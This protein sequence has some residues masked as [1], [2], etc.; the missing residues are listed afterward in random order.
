[1]K[2]NDYLIALPLIL[3]LLICQGLFFLVQRSTAE[4]TSNA[5]EFQIRETIRTDDMTPIAASIGNLESLKLIK[6]AKLT[7]LE[8]PVRE[9]VD[10]TNSIECDASPLLLQG[11][12]TTLFTNSTNG[13]RWRVSFIT[14]NQ[15]TFQIALNLARILGLGLILLSWQIVRVQTQ[16]QR[17]LVEVQ[18]NASRELTSIAN[19]VAHDI[20]SPLSVLA[21]SI[22]QNR[23]D[24]S[25]TA[26]LAIQRIEKIAADLLER[27][28]QNVERPRATKAITN[29]AEVEKAIGEMILE[30]RALID[31]V[32]QK[33][34]QL[35]SEMKFSNP[36]ECI[37]MSVD[38]LCRMLSNLINNS[39][40]AIES[41]GR[42][43]LSAYEIPSTGL[44]LV[45]Q[46][47]GA[48]MTTDQ[49]KRLETEGF[50]TKAAGNGLGLKSAREMAASVG[51][52]IVI[53]SRPGEGCIVTVQLPF[54]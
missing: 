35:V 41:A 11:S 17:K 2:Y 26:H 43:K 54:T 32:I 50:T 39:I 13:M 19:Q 30:K 12:P 5:I 15:L 7:R 24:G 22:D 1:M 27:R 21:Q 36:H 8:Q 42:I 18:L 29:I 33:P 3:W 53:L 31:N 52:S 34:I 49:V 37:G 47:D 23:N 40:E 4:Q 48:G 10:H 51:G 38:N 25:V 6:C 44:R 45:V 14:I 20:R 16:S 28:W 9:I 46:D